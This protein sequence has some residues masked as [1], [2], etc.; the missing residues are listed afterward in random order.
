[1]PEVRLTRTL[2][3]TPERVWA[4][5]TDLRRYPEWMALHDSFPAGP[6]PQLAEGV[7]FLQQMR[8][9]GVAAKIDWT[10]TTVRHCAELEMRGAGPLGLRFRYA[11]TGGIAA[12]GTALSVTVGL[13]GGPLAGPLG[14][15][16]GAVAK[17]EVAQGIDRSFEKLAALLG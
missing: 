17:R 16:T 1:M 9:R 13:A 4:L 8:V 3:V 15:A 12:G 11:V 6:P 5:A 7:S 10:V 2:P 14:V